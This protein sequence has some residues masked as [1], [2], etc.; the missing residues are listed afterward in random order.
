MDGHIDHLSLRNDAFDAM[1]AM[2][3]AFAEGEA[4]EDVFLRHSVPGHYAEGPI[5]RGII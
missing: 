1:I 4:L 3:I 5:I 2:G